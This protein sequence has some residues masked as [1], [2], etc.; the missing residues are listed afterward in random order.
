MDTTSCTSRRRMPGGPSE[1]HLT[2]SAASCAEIDAVAAGI[3]NL[4]Q[5]EPVARARSDGS[6]LEM[7]RALL[8][9][10]GIAFDNTGKVACPFSHYAR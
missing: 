2:V 8:E 10:E 3:S 7:K 4:L 5:G 1:L 6:Q 9:A